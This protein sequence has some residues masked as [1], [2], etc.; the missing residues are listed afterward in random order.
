MSRYIIS[1]G[2]LVELDIVQFSDKEKE[3]GLWNFPPE[4]IGKRFTEAI[5]YVKETEYI[6]GN[7]YIISVEDKDDSKIEN[8]KRFQG[9]IE[10]ISED[11]EYF[12]SP[13]SMIVD[14]I[15]TWFT[16]FAT[17]EDKLEIFKKI[18]HRLQIKTAKIEDGEIKF[19]ITE[20]NEGYLPSEA[21]TRKQHEEEKLK[22][23][24]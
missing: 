6:K 5:S 7:A 8:D 2:D 10:K 1:W 16:D 17:D 15:Y 19:T 14:D 23:Q 3:K 4:G 12:Y 21:I 13:W 9:L 11:F 20:G 18:Y 24:K 22:Y